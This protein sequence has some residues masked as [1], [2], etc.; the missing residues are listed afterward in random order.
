M[1][2]GSEAENIRETARKD[3]LNLLEGVSVLGCCLYKTD[4]PDLGQEEPGCQSGLGRPN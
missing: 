2:P 1:V 4:Q 3:L